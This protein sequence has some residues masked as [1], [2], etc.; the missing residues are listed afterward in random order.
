LTRARFN[1]RRLI[2]FTSSRRTN[3]FT[4]YMVG[5]NGRV[6]P[7]GRH[8]IHDYIPEVTPRHSRRSA[9]NRIASDQLAIRF[10]LV[11]TRS[12]IGLIATTGRHW[13]GH[14]TKYNYL[15]RAS[16]GWPRGSAAENKR[17]FSCTN[18]W[19]IFSLIILTV[20]LLKPFN[21]KSLRQK[22]KINFPYVISANLDYS[23]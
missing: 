16:R 4:I 5:S 10:H 15:R 11:I 9:G 13:P 7:I 17:K 19:N 18:K 12:W 22:C 20:G 1:P 14:R 8:A 6:D 2:G 3:L 21:Y 23:Y